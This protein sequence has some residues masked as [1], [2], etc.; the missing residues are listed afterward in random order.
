MSAVPRPWPS[1]GYKA[2]GSGQPTC[3]PYLS[4]GLHRPLQPAPLIGTGQLLRP[5]AARHARHRP[6]EGNSRRLNPHRPRHQAHPA[7]QPAR[8][9]ITQAWP[10]LQP[11]L[12]TTSAARHARHQPSEGNSRRLNPHRPGCQTHPARQPARFAITQAW[13][14]TATKHHTSSQ[15][16]QAPTNEGNSR[17]LNPHRPEHQAHPDRQQA[18]FAVTTLRSLQPLL[19]TTPAARHTR[20][21][22]N[23]GNSRKLNPHRTEHQA[24]PGHQKSTFRGPLL[25]TTPA[26][27]HTRQVPMRAIPKG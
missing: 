5:T 21:Q 8:F 15:A 13:Q 4:L 23:E 7:S 22:P 16:R 10:V 11:L 1:Q 26:A 17:R 9:A 24:H 27:R 3:N 2:S 18:R 14:A 25:S 6:S 12:S 19:S 20:H